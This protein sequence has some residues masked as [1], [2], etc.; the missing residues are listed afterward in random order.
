MPEK[1]Q[2][3]IITTPFGQRLKTVQMDLFPIKEIEVDG[4][5]MGV[6]SDGTPFLTGRGLAKICGVDPG[7][8]SRFTSNWDEERTKPRGKKILDLLRVQGHDGERLYLKTIKAGSETHVFTDAVCMAVLEY[9]AFESG[10]DN[11]VAL[12]NFRAL[13]R[14]SIRQFI[15]NRCGYDPHK[16]IPASWRNYHERVILNDQVPVGFFSIFREIA[17]IVIHL[18]QSGCPIDDHTVPD[19]SVGQHWARY[20]G[21]N[22]CDDEFGS[23]LQHPH[24]YPDWFPQSA[25][26]PV[27][28]WIYPV[29]ALG[30]FRLW[31]YENYIPLNFPKYVESKV[32]M[33]AF[34]P[35]HAELLINAVT[36]KAIDVE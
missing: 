4:I 14:F 24:N 33:G 19:I 1:P 21:D 27:P 11:G 34:L 17:D 36:R 35:S 8:F 12:R 9:Y 25:A 20:W 6:L 13:A 31:L 26:N 3:D 28:A 22:G 18:I 15:Y 29:G 7:A 2:S 23:R 32:K 5:A 30:V 16:H 10:Q